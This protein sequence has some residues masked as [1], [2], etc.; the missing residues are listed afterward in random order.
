ME[1]APPIYSALSREVC[2]PGTGFELRWESLEMEGKE[3]TFLKQSHH[4][5]V[6]GGGR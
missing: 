6:W 5:K 2:V 4:C 1:A 3:V